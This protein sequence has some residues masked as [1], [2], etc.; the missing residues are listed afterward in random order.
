MKGCGE[1]ALPLR[2][3]PNGARREEEESGNAQRDGSPRKQLSSAAEIKVQGCFAWSK[4]WPPRIE[5][6]LKGVVQ[7]EKC[8]SEVKEDEDQ[9]QLL[10]VVI[11][12]WGQGISLRGMLTPS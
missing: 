11:E 7:S 4:G 9:E 6:K 3:L 10:D 1:R 12:R 8:H 5:L 2:T